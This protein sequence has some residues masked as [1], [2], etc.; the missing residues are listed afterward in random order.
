MIRS[1]VLWQLL[2]N[3][4]HGPKTHFIAKCP[5]C[6]R[7]AHF[8]INFVTGLNDCKKC[9]KQGNIVTFLN[10]IGKIE[11]LDGNEVDIKKELPKLNKLNQNQTEELDIEIKTIK[12]PIGFKRT[13]YSDDNRFTEYLKSRKFT[14]LDFEIYQ[15][16]YTNLKR[17]YEDYVILPVNRDWE[18]KG[19]IVRY[20]GEDEEKPRYLNSQHDFSKLLFGYDEL[21]ENTKTVIIVEG[22]FDKISVTTELDL[23]NDDEAKC[24]CTFGKKLSDC[25][26][27]LLLNA[28]IE[29]LFICF[30]GRDAIKDIK[31]IGFKVK[32]QFNNILCCDT[33]TKF[34]PGA[35][36]K[37]M[38]LRVL[39][40]SKSIQKFQLDKL[41]KLR[42]K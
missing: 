3:P 2:E 27:L 20:I 18:V 37:N 31:N 40:E 13:K 16:G 12:L 14:E 34:D 7:D 30:D 22:V 9:G 35:S 6:K 23:H 17:K 32:R 26:L 1:D 25:Q 42:L 11:L 24:L 36:D 10:D 5:V 8:Y 21:T 41:A 4:K 39:N 15:P 38:L 28:G 29:N 33:G 19:Y